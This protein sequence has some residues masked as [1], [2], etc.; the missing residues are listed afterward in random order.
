MEPTIDTFAIDKRVAHGISLF[1]AK[2]PANWRAKITVE[3]LSMRSCYDCVGGQVFGSVDLALDQ[4][5]LNVGL[6][7]FPAIR[8]VATRRSDP[9]FRA[10]ILTYSIDGRLLEEHQGKD[11]I[12][13]DYDLLTAAW[14]RALAPGGA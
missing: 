14:K 6:D 1:N 4:L 12:D 9:G 5:G 7:I 8:C 11:R 2:G 10:G 3:K 13:A